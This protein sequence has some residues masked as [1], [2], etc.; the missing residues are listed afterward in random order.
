M[1]TFAEAKK[2]ILDRLRA[3][4]I[5]E[6]EARRESELIIL[7]ATESGT[8]EQFL[9]A[10]EAL[11]QSQVTE[12]ERVV[13]KR[14][15]RIPLQYC[16]G[17]TWFMGLPF[18][19]RPGVLIPRADT[20]SVVVKASK[21]IAMSD[22]QKD[23]KVVD[24]GVGSGA[25]AIS[26]LA[27]HPALS[28]T[29]LDISETACDLTRKNA[30]LNCVNDRLRIECGDWQKNL[31]S[32]IDVL[33]SNPPYIPA[34]QASGLQPEVGLHEPKE[35][36]FGTEE[37]GLGFYRDFAKLVPVHFRAGKGVIIVE[38]GD[39]QSGSVCRIFE[40]QDWQDLEVDLDMSQSPRVVTARK[41]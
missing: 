14:E 23:L 8:A 19:V 31:P 4:G 13:E 15:S 3:L 26:L 7:H 38:V 2:L 1:T 16:L 18:E 11:D 30:V 5:A 17:R 22:N 33:I 34:F 20:E 27:A 10:A 37:D 28:L 41:L 40:K 21:I 36:L 35:A 39:G 6:H 12:I 32:D 29:G 25:I 9:K 24:V